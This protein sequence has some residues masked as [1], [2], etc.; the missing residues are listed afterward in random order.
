MALR[1]EEAR[2]A[3]HEARRLE[4]EL[5]DA[6]AAVSEAALQ[7]DRQVRERAY[8][9]EQIG[10]LEKRRAEVQSEIEALSARLVGVGEECERLREHD[11]TLQ[12]ESE[13][14]SLSLSTA[15]QAY[16]EKLATAAN[17]EADIERARTE[18]LTHTAVA[19]KTTRDCLSV[20][21]HA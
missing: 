11:A 12:V 2:N 15:E 8:Q 1:E 3:T 17:A 21:R 19:R 16:A 4:D 13:Q 6:R 5:S 20:G 10:E 14:S 7:R 18:L 9:Q